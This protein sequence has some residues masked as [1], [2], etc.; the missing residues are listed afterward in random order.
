MFFDR[1][2]VPLVEATVRLPIDP[3]PVIG[4]RIA[5]IARAVRRMPDML[6]L[7]AQ[8]ARIVIDTLFDVPH[9]G[10]IEFHAAEDVGN[11]VAKQL[12][13]GIVHRGQWSVI[14]RYPCEIYA[15]RDPYRLTQPP[16]T[17]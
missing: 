1:T 17:G 9:A 16:P 15:A 6:R 5:K 13:G 4:D 3:V 2:G 11:V 12:R 8:E 14:V 7:K 10:A